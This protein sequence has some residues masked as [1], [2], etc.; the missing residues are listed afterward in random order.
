MKIK[1]Y[2]GVHWIGVSHD[3][4]YADIFILT[5]AIIYL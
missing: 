5:T 1:A 3:M 2:I 4:A